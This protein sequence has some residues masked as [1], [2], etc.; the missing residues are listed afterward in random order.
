MSITNEKLQTIKDNV[1]KVYRS[2][3][4]DVIKNA[5]SLKG[6][7]SNKAMLLDDVSPVAHKMGV[8]VRGKNLFDVSK[9]TNIK[10]ITNNGDGTITI[11]AN[12]YSTP[13][14]KSLKELCPDLKIGD[15]I[16]LSA[17]T[18]SDAKFIYLLTSKKE[19]YF[20]KYKTITQNDLDSRVVFYGHKTTS[21]KYGTPC[22]I[23]NIQIELGTTPT[24]YT[25]Y[26]PDLTAVTV[27]RYGKNLWDEIY[28]Q[29]H[30]SIS[31]GNIAST[32]SNTIRSVNFIPVKANTSYY[33][34][35]ASG[36]L[37]FCFYDK[38]KKYLTYKAAQNESIVSPPNSAFCRF[39]RAL[40][41]GTDYSNDICLS[42]ENHGYEAYKPPATYTPAADG[43]VN[44]VTSLYPNTTLM[45]DT[46]GVIIDCEYYKD[47]DK[48]FNELSSAIALSGGE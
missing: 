10:G 45:T 40:N 14:G 19:M 24:A 37:Y 26:V 33:I 42:F 12:S 48:A 28:A 38:D 27:S 13:T 15:I 16:T 3:Q 17:I 35:S 20:N 9:I 1:S 11:A 36:R 32:T 22:T 43:T 39:Y 41:S 25:P 5:N 31:T 47:I 21:E 44:G 30:L 4:M 2:G 23:S 34:F 8:R 18:E 46:D 7:E 6:F 29:G